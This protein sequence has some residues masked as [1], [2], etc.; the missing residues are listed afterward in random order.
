MNI[1]SHRTI[2]YSKGYPENMP[3][4]NGPTLWFPAWANA[5]S[6]SRCQHI[7]CH[8]A[9]HAASACLLAAPVRAYTTSILL[10]RVYQIPT[11]SKTKSPRNEANKAS[12]AVFNPVCLELPGKIC[13][14]KGLIY[15]LFVT[16]SHQREFKGRASLHRCTS[17]KDPRLDDLWTSEDK[18]R[19]PKWRVEEPSVDGMVRR[20]SKRSEG[21]PMPVS[22]M[23]TRIRFSLLD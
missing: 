16:N 9:P 20:F 4:P 7:I 2:Q 13:K 1:V 21:M 12:S 22:V 8:A 3:A 10:S 14:V 19:A 5:E 23:E 17:S 11:L 15:P 6:F 18:S